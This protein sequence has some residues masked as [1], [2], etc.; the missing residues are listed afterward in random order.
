MLAW[1]IIVRD[2]HSER[3]QH[4]TMSG[5]DW[6]DSRTLLPFG[7]VETNPGS[8]A[9]LCMSTGG[10]D[11]SACTTDKNIHPRRR[12]ARGSSSA[13]NKES[14]S[15]MNPFDRKRDIQIMQ[16]CSAKR[17]RRACD[18]CHTRR[19][20]VRTM[21]TQ[22]SHIY[23][24]FH[25]QMQ[26]EKTRQACKACISAGI[27]CTTLRTS[28]PRGLRNRVVEMIKRAG[29][30]ETTIES[31]GASLSSSSTSAQSASP[32]S[33][34]A[35]PER[36]SP[37]P[38]EYLLASFPA[39]EISPSSS[40][41]FQQEL[42]Q[43]EP[44]RSTVRSI[45]MTF[46]AES[47]F[48]IDVV[49]ALLDGFFTYLYPLC[50]FPHEQTF[51]TAWAGREDVL[52]EPYLALLASMLGAYIAT[53]PGQAREQ[54]VRS[55][56]LDEKTH[57]AN[58]IERCRR[59]CISARASGLV[60]ND[61]WRIHT[62]ATSYYLATIHFRSEQW[63]QGSV[64]LGEC[65]TVLCNIWDDP[66]EY[67]GAQYQSLT[68]LCALQEE[69]VGSAPLNAQTTFLIATGGGYIRETLP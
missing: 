16:Y 32:L 28:R 46:C 9:R 29:V 59:V 66:G 31:C 18:Y 15:R 2:I 43:G 23:K 51:R 48:P 42:S 20:K 40:P 3:V 10:D 11:D 8:A 68:G 45:S 4:R 27:S 62:A 39:K 25:S 26:C 53:F 5:D 55:Y 49:H 69:L 44:G 38:P 37:S 24:S 63:R 17:I 57:L 33:S 35:L 22:S 56:Y 61:G 13:L 14:N 12:K 52:S 54:I 41:V 1:P 7:Y 30:S 60:A 58:D 47:M 6:E 67:S 21:E 34:T 36:N 64:Y 19:T 50:P 65:F